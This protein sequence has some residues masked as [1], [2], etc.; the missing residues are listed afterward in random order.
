M[1]LATVSHTQGQQQPAIHNLVGYCSFD[2]SN[3]GRNHESHDDNLL[4]KIIT[5]QHKPP[6]SELWVSI[7]QK[8]N[9]AFFKSF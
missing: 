3:L 1:A 6:V 4:Q 8:H 9:M 7:L 5:L 2:P